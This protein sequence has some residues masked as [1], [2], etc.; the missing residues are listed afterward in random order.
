MFKSKQEIKEEKLIKNKISLEKDDELIKFVYKNF[1]NIEIFKNDNN[2]ERMISGMLYDSFTDKTVLFRDD[3]QQLVEEYKLIKY[4]DYKDSKAYQAARTEHLSKLLGYIGSNVVLEYPFSC[5]Y[6]CNIFID[7]NTYINYN[8]T[9]ADVSIVKIGKDCLIGPSCII[10]TATHPIDI[11][12]RACG[13]ENGKKI[14]IQD[15]VWLGANVKVLPGVTIGYG[16][17]IGAGSVVNKDVPPFSIA[18]GVPAK[19]IKTIDREDP[20]FDPDLYWSE[21]S[22][23]QDLASN[24]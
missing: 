4:R 16:S 12:L 23:N 1:K 5:D 14:I 11:D 2:Y 6:G 19:V 20:H 10:C 7:D 13:L 8:F 3:A 24:L 22:E 17:I 15:K 21:I 18:V 9:A